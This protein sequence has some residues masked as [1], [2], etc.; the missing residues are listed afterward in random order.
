LKTG[1]KRDAAPTA[2]SAFTAHGFDPKIISDPERRVITGGRIG[3]DF[4]LAVAD[5]EA[6]AVRFETETLSGIDQA[7]EFPRR[8][9]AR[10]V[11]GLK[12]K[13][14]RMKG[15]RIRLA[16]MIGILL[17]LTGCGGPRGTFADMPKEQKVLHSPL[18]Q[19]GWYPDDPATL[20]K[21]LGEYLEDASERNLQN[22]QA[23][24]LPHAGYRYSG[25]VAAEALKQVA[26]RSFKR[27]IVLGPS[28]SVAMK[29][30]ASLPRAT[31]YATVLGEIPLDLEC[32]ETLLE[33][34]RFEN[35]SRAHRDEHSVQIEVPLLQAALRPG[36][37]LV[38]VVVG[39]IGSGAAREMASAL[40]PFLDAETLVVVSTDFTHYG[41]RFGYV[42]F[43]E[44]IEHNLRKLDL[45]AFET[46]RR[47]DLPAFERYFQK[48]GITVCGRC[49]VMILL[50]LLD[51]D[52]GVHKITY[53]TSGELTGDFHNSVS[54]LSAAF[55][56]AWKTESG[57]TGS[58]Q[59][60]LSRE[61]REHLLA[62]ARRSLAYYL[63]H[64]KTPDPDTLDHPVTPGMKQVMGAFVT[65]HKRG[66]LR[67]CIG[68]IVPRRA[69]YLA[70]IDHAVNAGVHDPRFPPVTPDELPLLEFEIS[71]LTP[72]VPVNSPDQIQLGRHGIVLSKNGRNAVFL[73]QVAPEQGWDLD[74]TLTHLS[75]KARLPAD[76]WKRDAVF[77]VFEAIVFSEETVS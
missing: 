47:K 37:R 23:L 71:A 33:S 46:I 17:V 11:A 74:E 9:P 1:F 75:L 13:Q 30:I 38:P 8:A 39:Q 66:R 10:P 50:A 77:Q 3:P 62:L 59:P 73:P 21:M 25:R 28:H 53:R 24:L 5:T 19:M 4:S 27:V 43:R 61:D 69:L 44:N 32:M 76:A 45:D 2:A 18:G 49:P 20:R 67:G 26:G 36:F 72:P 56:D 31:H 51:P 35:V 41:P 70:V 40:R 58:G 29:D 63:E 48:T 15:A 6:G 22:V 60:S 55:T 12:G 54:Y 34:P 64:G 7:L 57:R 52:A 65:L 42:P 68:E 14:P 16:R